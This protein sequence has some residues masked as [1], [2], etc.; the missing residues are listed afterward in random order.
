[1]NKQ[2]FSVFAATLILAASCSINHKDGCTIKFEVE[3][4]TL[5]QVAVLI[6]RTTN[7]TVDLDKNGKGEIELKNTGAIYPVI[8]YGQDMMPVFIAKGDKATI[9]FNGTAFTKGVDV[10]GKC[11]EATKYLQ[12]LM[13]PE[14]QGYDKEFPEFKK[15]IEANLK[16]C[17]ADLKARGLDEKCPEFYAL[18]SERLR[19]ICGQGYIMYPIGYAMMKELEAYTPGEEYFEVLSTYIEEKPKL[20]DV[21][22]YRSFLQFAIPSLIS[23]ESG[24]EITDG[25]DRAI[26]TIKYL[27]LNFEDQ[28]LKD[29]LI[30]MIA[31]DHI[32]NFGVRNTSELHKMVK[33]YIKDPAYLD[34]IE[35][36]YE[37]ENPIVVGKLS[38]EFK[39]EKTDGSTCSLADFQGKYLYIDI[40]ATWCAPCRRELPHFKALEERFA[41]RDITF[42]GLSIDDDKARWAEMVNSGKTSS[43]QAL[44]DKESE[45]LEAYDVR[46]IPR[47]ILLDKEGKIVNPNM[48]QPS[49][50]QVVEMLEKL[51]L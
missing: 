48:V 19:Y 1:M 32:Q 11:P 36:I 31:L 43:H 4:L 17:L 20:A 38:P 26:K 45:F 5:S 23:H 9:H 7:Y 30:R 34:E 16:T 2:R 29:K 21:D 49:S 22:A 41:D 44:I 40:W 47:F 12:T 42:L 18:E 25:Y 13:V 24:E 6:D 15:E 35:S 3:D 33:A 10:V 37:A 51:G 27:A 28:T 8:G 14:A 50:G 46:S 39:A